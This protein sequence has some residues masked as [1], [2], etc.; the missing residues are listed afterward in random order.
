MTDS[1]LRRSCKTVFLF[2]ESTSKKHQWLIWGWDS[3]WIGVLTV[4]AF[5]HSF[6]PCTYMYIVQV[7]VAI[8]YFKLLVG[9]WEEKAEILMALSSF[10]KIIYLVISFPVGFSW[11]NQEGFWEVG[12]NSNESG[13]FYC[14][15]VVLACY[16]LSLFVW[17]Y[18]NMVWC[19]FTNVHDSWVPDRSWTH[20][21]LYTVQ[22]P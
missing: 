4:L 10:R 8:N 12:F 11:E 1:D 13:Q 22:M 14:L 16:M 20:N 19:Q 9:R 15:H 21:L 18:V 17:G 6:S 2:L 7:H 5:L 3:D